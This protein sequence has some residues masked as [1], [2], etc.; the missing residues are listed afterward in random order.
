MGS[1]AHAGFDEILQEMG[2]NLT[3]CMGVN[4]I[5]IWLF[6]EKNSCIFC[7][8]NYNSLTG[9]FS[10]GEVLFEN[11]IPAYFSHLKK[12]KI[13][14]INDT[15]TNPITSDLRDNY[16]IP[17]NI[18]SM[19][20]VPIRIEG[21]LAG[22]LCYEHTGE[23]R[24]WTDE[25]QHFALAVNQVVAMAIESQQRKE[26]QKKLEQNLHEKEILMA[27][28]HHRIKN[29]LSILASLLRL[30]AK[31]TNNGP[32]I[33]ILQEVESKVLSIA[34]LHEQLYV[35]GSYLKVELG[36]Y[37]HTLVSEFEKT[38]KSES[39][40]IKFSF[41]S[42]P[43]EQNTSKALIVGLIV[44][45]I[46]SNSVKYAFSTFKK[47]IISLS[48]SCHGKNVSLQVSD[49]GKGFNPEEM[50]KKNSLG[51]SLIYDLCEQLD[52]RLTAKS[53]SSGTSYLI[54]F[55]A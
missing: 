1:L 37:L 2:K 8:G 21:K 34:R 48:L 29:N 27:E 47:S 16:C 46:L 3:H 6:R 11:D 33:E 18:T 17:N 4:R 5:N 38:A 9:K 30:Q 51:V 14:T 24:E 19:M 28:M 50:R 40:P 25:E 52:A 54:E 53:N 20:D 26:L 13:L 36:H 7:I 44:N 23:M 41:Q 10:K 31:E 39:K 43:C 49:N 15:N 55:Q 22:V 45:E 12:D 35:A 32:A 42:E